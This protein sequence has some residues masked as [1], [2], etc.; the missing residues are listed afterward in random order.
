MG[1]HMEWIS[2]TA[3]FLIIWWVML[4][5]ALPIGLRT[6][7]DENNVVLGTPASAPGTPH[8]LRTVVRTTLWTMIVF[9]IFYVTT[10][11]FGFSFDDIPRVAPSFLFG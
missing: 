6:Q 4:F 3:I 2:L 5:V 11:V 1:L 7:D 10:R 9:G 8:M